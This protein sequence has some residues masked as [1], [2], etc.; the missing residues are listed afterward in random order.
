MTK[1]R[2]R[3][4]SGA[5]EAE[6][7]TKR[8]ANQ[9]RENSTFAQKQNQQ[10]DGSFTIRVDRF[11]L[12]EDHGL[13]LRKVDWCVGRVIG[14]VSRWNQDHPCNEVLLG[15]VI[16]NVN[17]FTWSRDMAKE[18]GAKVGL[19]ISPINSALL[20]NASEHG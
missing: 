2:H 13:Q 17:G 3:V 16:T 14:A 15:D 5:A 20:P 7:V 11:S 1:R 4:R 10:R 12:H 18:L 9:A 19:E 6:R 8:V